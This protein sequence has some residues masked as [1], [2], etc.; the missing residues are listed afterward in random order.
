MYYGPQ[1]NKIH[2]FL[3][4]QK[5]HH[6][7]LATSTIIIAILSTWAIFLYQPLNSLIALE[8]QQAA[9]L[10]EKQ[11][12][13]AQTKM[14]ALELEKKLNEHKKILTKYTHQN[15]NKKDLLNFILHQAY[16]AGLLSSSCSRSLEKKDKKINTFNINCKF[17][18]TLKQ[19]QLFFEKLVA[20][21]YHI[22]CQ[23][24][25]ITSSANNKQLEI[26]A[27]FN[28]HVIN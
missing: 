9:S 13:A 27:T 22:G 1:G 28:Y 8:Q 2:S 18:G 21:E 7:Y 3:L 15:I 24:L 5:K 16:Q 26:S 6:R 25:T 4:R 20:S 12:N 11:S 19:V 14:V 17:K 10:E 23:N